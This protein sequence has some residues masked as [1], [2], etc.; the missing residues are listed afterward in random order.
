MENNAVPM[1]FALEPERFWAEL[2]RILQEEM[3]RAGQASAPLPLLE[4]PGLSQKP[5]Y[6]MSEICSLFRVSRPT[7]YEWIKAGKLRPV[8]IRSRVYFLGAEIHLLLHAPVQR[9]GAD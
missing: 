5:L 6:K 8:K 9:A 2:R 1:F 7:V 4:T 3:A